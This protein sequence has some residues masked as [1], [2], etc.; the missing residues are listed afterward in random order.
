[1]GLG[2]AGPRGDALQDRGAVGLRPYKQLA[3]E[4]WRG[5]RPNSAIVNPWGVSDL[6]KRDPP[7]DVLQE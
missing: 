7:W 5:M 6:A 4:A 1:M 2:R 3:N